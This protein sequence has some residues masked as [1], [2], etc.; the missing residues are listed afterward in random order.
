M[1]QLV[2]GAMGW[3]SRRAARLRV[4]LATAAGGTFLIASTASHA[5]EAGAQ[6]RASARAYRAA[7]AL[8]ANVIWREESREKRL[9]ARGTVTLQKPNL[10]RLEL[11]P[12]AG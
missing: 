5:D 4:V 2:N 6:L 7:Q 1:R 12:T 9:E 10:A 8:S 11:G 3:L